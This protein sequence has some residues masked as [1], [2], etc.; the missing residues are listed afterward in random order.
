LLKKTNQGG[1]ANVKV[2]AT[3]KPS[4][5]LFRQL[6]LYKNATLVEARPLTGRTHQIRVHA[7]WLGH[8]LVGDARYGV[9]ETNQLFRKKGYKR[10]FLHAE[11]LQFAHP[12][13]GEVLN[14]TAPLPEELQALL[15]N[16]QTN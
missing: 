16:E 13:S 3:G 14:L 9:E 5:T 11:K 6:A 12:V 8:P 15:N 10:M 1:G 7:A 4:Q 2:H